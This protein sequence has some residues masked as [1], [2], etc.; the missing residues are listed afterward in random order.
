VLVDHFILRRRRQG[1]ATT[2]LRWMTLLAWIGG[3]CIYHLLANLYPDIGATLP[4]LVVAGVLQWVL[5]RAK[6]PAFEADVR[7]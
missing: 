2:G 1:V 5:A 3:I 7:H 4:A 6:A